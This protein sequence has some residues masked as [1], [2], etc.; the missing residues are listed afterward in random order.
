MTQIRAPT[1]GSHRKRKT[2]DAGARNNGSCFY[3]KK[4]REIREGD[5]NPFLRYR[6]LMRGNRQFQ[7]SGF[8]KKIYGIFY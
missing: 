5:E 7:G 3:L 4:H 8:Q 1:R 2:E 6:I